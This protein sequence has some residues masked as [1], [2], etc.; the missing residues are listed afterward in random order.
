MAFHPR[1]VPPRFSVSADGTGAPVRGRAVLS[2]GDRR[3][4]SRV[5]RASTPPSD[6]RAAGVD[7]SPGRRAAQASPG[8]HGEAASGPRASGG[9]GPG[10]RVF[11]EEVAAPPGASGPSGGQSGPGRVLPS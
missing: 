5:A 4:A 8:A 11:P 6:G 2:G 9:L 3:T 7:R 10:P 1:H